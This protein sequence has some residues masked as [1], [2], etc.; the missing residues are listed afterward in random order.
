MHLYII[1]LSCAN[2]VPQVVATYQ[3]HEFSPYLDGLDKAV[4]SVIDQCGSLIQDT[5]EHIQPKYHESL[6]IGGLARRLM[7]YIGRLSGR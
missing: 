6:R 2:E 5:L 7:L 4:K 3:Q 1:M